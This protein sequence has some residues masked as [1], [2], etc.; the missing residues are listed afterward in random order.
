MG[1][2]RKSNAVQIDG[3][4]LKAELNSRGLT[5]TDAARAVGKSDGYL[6]KAG[7]YGSIQASVMM[8]LE[9]I[10]GITPESIAP[11]YPAPDEP[12]Q[13]PEPMRSA[14][15]EADWDRL[16]RLI[17]DAILAADTLREGLT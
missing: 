7:R 2:I 14:L 15:T 3:E 12:E 9:K 16:S 5:L 17:V 1:T 8:L 10:Y 6:A 11:V 13:N 4:R